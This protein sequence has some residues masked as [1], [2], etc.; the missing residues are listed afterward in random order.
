MTNFKKESNMER[1]VW[2]NSEMFPDYASGDKFCIAE[3][4]GTHEIKSDT[5]LT[6]R[7]CASARY[8]LYVNDEFIGRGPASAGLDYFEML[9]TTLYYDE[10]T[11]STST[12]VKI[13]ALVTS[14]DTAMCERSCG[15]AGLYLELF[16]DGEKI[17]EADSSWLARPLAE[18]VDICY[19]DYTRA[20]YELAP[21]CVLEPICKLEKSPL[22]PL[23][24]SELSPIS[25]DKISLKSPTGCAVFDKIYSAYPEISLKCDGR[26]R[27]LLEFAEIDGIGIFKEEFVASANIV[28]TSPRMRAIGQVKITLEPCEASYAEIDSVKIINSIYPVKNETGFKS[29]DELID[30]IYDLCIHTLKN[31]RRDLHLDSPTH[32]EPLACTG[33][34][35]IQS[36]MEHFNM[37]DPTLSAFDILR[38]AKILE[39]NDGVMFH[40]SYSL[41]LPQWLHD[42]YLYTG[43]SSLV[44]KCQGALDVL[45]K[46]FESYVGENGLL[47]RAPNYMFVDWILLDEDGKS[48]DPANM[49]NHGGFKGFSLHHP[50]K[51]LGQAVLCMLYYNALMKCAELYEIILEPEMIGVCFDKAYALKEA[52]NSLLFDTE[53]A[54][55]LGGLNTP[56]A[57]PSSDWLPENT[58]TRYYLKQANVLAV[59][60]DIAPR[61]MRTHILEYVLKDLK[62]EEMQPYFY[63]FLLEA[64]IKTDLFE[65]YGLD[66]IRRYGSLVEKCDKGLCE[67]WEGFPGDCSHAWGGAPAYILKK[68]ISGF[69][70]V[71]AGYKRVRLSPRLFDLDFASLEISTPYG[72]IKLELTKNKKTITAPDEIEIIT[73]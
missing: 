21:V 67:A 33:D 29:S 20:Q 54:L 37:H 34:Y 16:Q 52:I 22:E 42:Y 59:L 13:R 36:L 71:D 63:Y 62:K 14:A 68:A 55:Y 18:R 73:N 58:D 49:M 28:H 48:T 53:R 50:P 19:T 56:N 17:A 60:Y 65:K 12:Q 57:I 30:K 3:L 64:L 40:T 72:P 8:M 2:L 51:A 32:Q 25:F 6:I 23:F 70:M 5:P 24:E 27:V 43:D 61:E 9:A 39:R 41:M 11:I 15:K 1:W 47:E 26:V 38:T 35:L 44:Y 31:C 7:V 69:E 45:L 66:L 46:R 10:Y 4:V